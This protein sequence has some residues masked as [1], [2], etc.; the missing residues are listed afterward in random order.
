MQCDGTVNAGI[1]G[2]PQ[3]HFNLEDEVVSAS[4]V[5]PSLGKRQLGSLE[6]AAVGLDVNLDINLDDSKLSKR[7]LD[8]ETGLLTGLLIV[9]ASGG[10][11][12]TFNKRQIATNN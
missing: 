4:F 12:Q 9:I 3:I 5:P 6:A 7:Q 11:G 10:D 8:V 1:Y 2:G